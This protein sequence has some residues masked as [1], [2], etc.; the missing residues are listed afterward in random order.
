MPHTPVTEWVVYRMG[1]ILRQVG[2]NAICTQAEWDAMELAGP[3]RH[4]LIRAHI[5]NEGEAERLARDL[6]T[7]PA[8]PKPPRKPVARRSPPPPA[9][10]P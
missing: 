2:Q 8:A 4:T 3:G 9:P 10:A 1:V 7:P 6:Q 5:G